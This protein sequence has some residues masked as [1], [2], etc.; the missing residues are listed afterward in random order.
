MVQRSKVVAA[1]VVTLAA[2]AACEKLTEIDTNTYYGGS[3]NGAKEKPAAVTTTATGVAS[4]TV[5][6][7]LVLTYTVTWS[8]LSGAVSGAHIHGPADSNNTAGVLI[9]FSSLPAGSSNQA[10]ALTETGSA[11]GTVNVTASA[12]ITPTVSGDSL[13]KL[14]NAGL[15]YV[16]IH[17]GT[18]VAG[19]I[20]AQLRRH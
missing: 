7:G 6:K 10:I 5:T 14:M 20:R 11:T 9:D 16:N 3:L 17:A 1:I 18:N 2:V 12:V 8:G 13:I 4:I 19:E 15:T